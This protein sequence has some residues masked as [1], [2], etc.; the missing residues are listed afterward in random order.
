MADPF[1]AYR[2]A[3]GRSVRDSIRL[4]GGRA[5]KSLGVALYKEGLGIMASSQGLVPVDTTALRSSGYV[6]EPVRDI[7]MIT[8]ELGYGG[9]AAKINSKTG[10]STDSY[11]LYVHENLETFHPVGTAKYLEMPFDQAKT[12]MGARIA[13]AIR[14]DMHGG[15]TSM[16]DP[17]EE[18]I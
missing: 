13:A 5:E 18:A 6:K 2:T 14:A 17:G 15:M 16:G 10:E 1:K 7:N 9:P 8:V 11:A 12:G 3:S 4:W